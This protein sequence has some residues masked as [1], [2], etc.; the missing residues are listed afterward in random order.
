MRKSQLE[1]AFNDK[2]QLLK[3]HL[4]NYKDGTLMR[5]DRLHVGK[6]GEN[7]KL[8]SK[9]SFMKSKIETPMLPDFMNDYNPG[10]WDEEQALDFAKSQCESAETLFVNGKKVDVHEFKRRIFNA[11]L[12][13]HLPVFELT[14][15]KK[16]GGD[17]AKTINKINETHFISPE[18]YK[19]LRDF[20][21]KRGGKLHL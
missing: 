13:Q 11:E 17:M 14:E 18:D 16:V 20:D 8:G 6:A 15:I 9:F 19:Q 3:V 1:I 21:N 5:A 10:E 7:L 2:E 4:S 12:K